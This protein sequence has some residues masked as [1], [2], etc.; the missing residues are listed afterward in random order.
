MVS[1]SKTTTTLALRC[2]IRKWASI[3][4]FHIGKGG[5]LHF[6]LE[7]AYNLQA[8]TILVCAWF[9]F[10]RDD[11]QTSSKLSCFRQTEINEIGLANGLSVRISR[12]YSQ[13]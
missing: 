2:R 4:L 5:L 1:G 7:S 9:Y 10:T 12:L 13:M 8:I 3:P 6:K 11:I